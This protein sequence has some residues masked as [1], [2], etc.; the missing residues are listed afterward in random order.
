MMQNSLKNDYQFYG[1]IGRINNMFLDNGDNQKF[2][3]EVKREILSDNV[4]IYDHKGRVIELPKGSTIKDYA[5][6][7]KRESWLIP[8]GALVNNNFEKLNYELKNKDIV[9]LVVDDLHF[10]IEDEEL[11]VQKIAQSQEQIYNETKVK[12]FHI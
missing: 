6:R 5:K 7:T 1:P 10:R 3:N 12:K 9:E 11:L 4:Y 8:V 2:V